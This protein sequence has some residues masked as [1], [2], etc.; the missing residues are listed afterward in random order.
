MK[1]TECGNANSE[2]S[3]KCNHSIQ[4]IAWNNIYSMMHC[5]ENQGFN[6]IAMHVCDAIDKG[7]FTNLELI[8]VVDFVEEYNYFPEFVKARNSRYSHLI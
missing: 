1:C 5:E 8:D 2:G 7:E 6:R 3:L 4:E